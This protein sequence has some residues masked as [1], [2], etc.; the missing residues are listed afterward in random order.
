MEIYLH[1]IDLTGFMK[2]ARENMISY[3]LKMAR[4][5]QASSNW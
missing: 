1:S 2:L 5:L 4:Q 3:P